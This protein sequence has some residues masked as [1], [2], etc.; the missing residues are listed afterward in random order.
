MIDPTTTPSTA[1]AVHHSA[2]TTP[3]TCQGAWPSLFDLIETRTAI[4]GCAKPPLGAACR[5]YCWDTRGV[6][7]GLGGTDGFRPAAHVR[8]APRGP[9]NDTT[10]TSSTVTTITST[11]TT[12]IS[13]GT[14]IISTSTTITSTSTTISSTGTTITSI[15]TTSTPTITTTTVMTIN[16]SLTFIASVFAGRFPA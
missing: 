6:G 16:L 1:A 15:T 14:T 7:C 9:C 3:Q 13:T 4:K 12:I 2:T 11:G 5:H 10:I 8:L